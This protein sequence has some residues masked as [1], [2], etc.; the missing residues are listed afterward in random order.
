MFFSSFQQLQR[1]RVNHHLYWYWNGAVSWRPPVACRRR[2]WAVSF[3][4]CTRADLRVPMKEA[5]VWWITQQQPLSCYSPC[6][7]NVLRWTY[8]VFSLSNFSLSSSCRFLNVLLSGKELS[9]LCSK[10]VLFFLVFPLVPFFMI[11]LLSSL[12]HIFV[13]FA[14]L[15]FLSHLLILCFLFVCTIALLFVVWFASK[16]SSS[17]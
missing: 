15:F 2:N 16:F 9:C 1:I 4:V 12:V 6:S 14:R 10:L 7:L 13:S 11:L 3:V 8:T 5:K 17:G